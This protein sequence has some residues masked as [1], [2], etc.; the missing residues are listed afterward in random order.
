MH[1]HFGTFVHLLQSAFLPFSV[2]WVFVGDEIE[3]L[4]KPVG[5]PGAIAVTYLFVGKISGNY[6]G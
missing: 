1:L 2:A 6:G 5:K 3:L 4:L